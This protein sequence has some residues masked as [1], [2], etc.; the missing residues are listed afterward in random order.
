MVCSAPMAL[1]NMTG[2]PYCDIV[3]MEYKAYLPT[4]SVLPQMYPALCF[5]VLLVHQIPT[6]SLYGSS[7]RQI[8]SFVGRAMHVLVLS[9][10]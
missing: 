8:V 9:A 5:A 6:H 10:I 4:I 7:L 2:P 3:A 1:F